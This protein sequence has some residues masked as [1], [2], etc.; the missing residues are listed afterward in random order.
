MSSSLSKFWGGPKSLSDAIDQLLTYSSWR[1]TKTAILLFNK[2]LN[3]STVLAKVSE[4]V[5]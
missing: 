5:L 2:R 4:V 3:L 1:D